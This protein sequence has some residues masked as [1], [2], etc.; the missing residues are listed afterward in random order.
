MGLTNLFGSGPLGSSK[1]GKARFKVKQ[2]YKPHALSLIIRGRVLG[3]GPG[4]KY[5]FKDLSLI[6]KVYFETLVEN[7]NEGISTF[8]KLNYRF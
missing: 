2:T 8:F 5:N 3:I 6:G 7:R 1:H 4:V